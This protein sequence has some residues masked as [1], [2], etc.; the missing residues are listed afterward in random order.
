MDAVLRL[1]PEPGVDVGPDLGPRRHLGE[2][3][4]RD[5]A[6]VDADGL[7]ELYEGVHEKIREDPSPSEKKAFT[8]NKDYK[9]KAKLTLDERKARVQAKKDAKI[10]ELEADS[11][12]E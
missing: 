9:R 8:P 11:D 12:D 6:L 7:E 3:E 5:A 4:A 10:A 2:L 1:G